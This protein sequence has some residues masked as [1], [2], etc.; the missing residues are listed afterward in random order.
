MSI[1]IW[2]MSSEHLFCSVVKACPDVI[3][4]TF[5]HTFI[6]ENATTEADQPF[7]RLQSKQSV[8]LIRAYGTKTKLQ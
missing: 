7:I 1:D 8:D 6:L 2:T 3:E 4:K 5:K